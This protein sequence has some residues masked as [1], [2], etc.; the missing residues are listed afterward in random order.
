MYELKKRIEELYARFEEFRKPLDL[1]AKREALKKLQKQSQ[2]PNLWDDP[3][4]ARNLMQELSGVESEITEVDSLADEIETLYALAQED[5][6]EESLEDDVEKLETTL[7]KAELATYLS[8]K[9][10][11][12]NAIVSLHAGQ[13]GTEAMDWSSMLLRMYLR[14]C[15]KRGWK[16]E[17][18]EESTG[19]EAGIKSAT[20]LVYG[21]Y[22]YGYLKNESGAH[23]LV[24]QS[25]FNAD[26]LRQTSFALV[27]VMPELDDADESDMIIRDDDLDIQFFRSSGS[28]GQNVNKVSTAV[29]ITHKPTGIVVSS[30]TQRYQVQN[31]KS[32]MNLLRAKLWAL[33]EEKRMKEENRIKGDY[34]PASWGAQI[35]SYVLHPYKMV[36]DLRTEVETSNAEAVLDGDLDLFVDSGVKINH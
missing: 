34:T 10:D 23:R 6:I 7:D 11:K 17:M 27:E 13:G 22:A 16:T 36:K 9:Y 24:R 28:G 2:D 1:D 15:E 32:A 29:R 4:R 33:E 21:M 35:R 12:R 19:E 20:F 3:D 25:P 18:I 30:Q 14:F 26:N 8:G 31:R 5:E